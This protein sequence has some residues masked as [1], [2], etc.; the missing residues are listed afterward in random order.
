MQSQNQKLL[1]YV[2]NHNSI[3]QREAMI[4]LGIGRLSERIRELESKGVVFAREMF[5]TE[6]GKAYPGC[7]GMYT[8]YYYRG[9]K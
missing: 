8:R 6:D 4:I 1:K 7:V 5:K 9:L 2:V 3:T